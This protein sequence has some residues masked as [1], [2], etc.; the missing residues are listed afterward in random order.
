MGDKQAKREKKLLKTEAKLEA[1]RIKAYA[2]A[3]KTAPPARRTSAGVRFAE[4]VRGLLFIVLAVSLIGAL[5][6]G[7]RDAIISLEDV[8]ESLFLA[9]AGKILLGVIAVAFFIYGLKY[10]RVVK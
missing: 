7:Q 5:F 6:L 4:A 3:G 1:K 8:I 2:K 10:L 9:T